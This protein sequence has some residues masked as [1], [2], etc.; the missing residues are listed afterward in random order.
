MATQK[1]TLVNAIKSSGHIPRG[2]PC[3]KQDNYISTGIYRCSILDFDVKFCE[4][5]KVSRISAD[6]RFSL[7]L[8]PSLNPQPGLQGGLQLQSYNKFNNFPKNQARR[9]DFCPNLGQGRS[10]GGVPGRKEF[11]QNAIE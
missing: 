5:F 8:H 1:P 10:L 2:K 3:R 11:C 7:C 9:F 6:K 4:N